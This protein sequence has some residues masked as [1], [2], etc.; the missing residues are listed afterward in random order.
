MKLKLKQ[1]RRSGKDKSRKYLYTETSQ[2]H[3]ESKNILR[4]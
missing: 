4:V 3:L 2:K 1:I